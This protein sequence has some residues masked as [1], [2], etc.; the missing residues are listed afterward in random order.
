ME[1]RPEAGLVSTGGICRR[2][3]QRTWELATRPPRGSLEDEE[4]DHV[5]GTCVDI[6]RYHLE[7]ASGCPVR[8]SPDLA[9]VPY[10]QSSD[11][12]T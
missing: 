1:K 8:A 9:L 3:V 11:L 12:D 6:V 4:V 10:R 7:E 2:Q 5:Q